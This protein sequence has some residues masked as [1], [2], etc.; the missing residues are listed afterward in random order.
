MHAKSV[1]LPACG[2]RMLASSRPGRGSLKVSCTATL[3]PAVSVHTRQIITCS[4]CCLWHACSSFLASSMQLAVVPAW[5]LAAAAAAALASLPAPIHLHHVTSM[6]LSAA[7]Y[8]QPAAHPY[9]YLCLVCVN[10]PRPARPQPA[11]SSI[12]L[13]R[14]VCEQQTRK[15]P[16]LK[17]CAAAR[18]AEHVSAKLHP[19]P[20]VQL[21][22][23]LWVLCLRM[24]AGCCRNSDGSSVSHQSTAACS[25]QCISWLD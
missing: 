16:S 8:S 5:Q 18:Q 22:K 17:R 9:S 3:D 13:R 15:H 24:A 10:R 19:S 11:A 25:L 20:A 21:G 6:L 1:H 12:C 7:S 2:Q 4:V 14:R 23:R